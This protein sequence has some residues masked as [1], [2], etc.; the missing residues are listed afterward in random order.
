MVDSK[1]ELNAETD[2]DEPKKKMLQKYR[3]GLIILEDDG[4]MGQTM[5][6]LEC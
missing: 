5:V 6:Q 2:I 1:I 4:T 3:P